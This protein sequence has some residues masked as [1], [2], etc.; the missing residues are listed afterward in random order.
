M[1]A[2]AALVPMIL[3][4]AAISRDPAAGDDVERT[5]DVGLDE[6]AAPLVVVVAPLPKRA[7]AF[8]HLHWVHHRS[9]CSKP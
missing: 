5:S 2:L 9:R 3:V 1:I 8:F 6:V 4:L 7:Q